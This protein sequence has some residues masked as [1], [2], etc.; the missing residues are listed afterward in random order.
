MNEIIKDDQNFGNQLD[1]PD[2]KKGTYAR[3]AM[4]ALGSIPWVGGFIAGTAAYQAEREQGRINEN[5]QTWMNE[6]EQKI[7]ELY[8]TLSSI[9]VRIEGLGD[10]AKARIQEDDYLDLVRKGFRIWDKTETRDKREL[11]KRLLTNAAGT[12]VTDDD[13]VRLFL[14]WIDRYHESHFG[15]IRA[16]YQNP[17]ISLLGIWRVLGNTG[18][19][20]RENSSSADLFRM[21]IHDLSTGRVIRQEREVNHLGQFLK[22]SRHGR[23]APPSD[24]MKSSFDDE[25]RH[26]LTE[27]GQEFVHYV[28]SESVSRI[29]G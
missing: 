13:V 15:I 25:D 10:E 12:T 6:H 4:A 1:L 18:E 23:R 3:F 17:G 21:L 22:K 27:L 26:E 8:R 2:S 29:E 11:I 14:D 7:G 19:V 9:A 20:P 16:V 28:L 5:I 24:V